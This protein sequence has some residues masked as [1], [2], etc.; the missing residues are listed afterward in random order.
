MSSVRKSMRVQPRQTRCP[1]FVAWFPPTPP[2]PG[3]ARIAFWAMYVRRILA[4]PLPPLPT[5][6]NPQ[7]H[8][9]AGGKFLRVRPTCYSCGLARLATKKTALISGTRDFLTPF[10]KSRPS[11]P[12]REH[13]YSVF[14]TV[15]FWCCDSWRFHAQQQHAHIRCRKKK[16]GAAVHGGICLAAHALTRSNCTMLLGSISTCISPACSHR[17]VSQIGSNSGDA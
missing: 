13:R 14:D 10:T 16:I 12:R 17:F 9:P 2:S 5:T 1:C 3:L 4:T 7:R 6:A 8:V 11:V 15:N